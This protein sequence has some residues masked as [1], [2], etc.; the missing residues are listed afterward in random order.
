MTFDLEQIRVVHKNPGALYRELFRGLSLSVSAGECVGIL[1]REGSGKT[2]LL[3]L[4]GGLRRPDTGV[5][6]IDGM[7]PWKPR[8]NGPALRRRIG[9]TFQFPDEQ[10]TCDT[11]AGEITASGGSA[12]APAMK[13]MLRAAGLDPE[14]VLTQSPFTLSIGEARRFAL[15]LTL[16]RRPDAAILDEPTAGLDADGFASALQAIA[17]LRARRATVIFATHDIDFLGAC[18]ERVVLLDEGGI[19]ADGSAIQVLFD[20]PLLASMG[21]STHGA[22]PPGR[23]AEW[24]VGEKSVPMFRGIPAPRPAK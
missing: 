13:S 19:V 14:V 12:V 21:Y 2:T 15:A 7:D 24:P 23:Q 17:E 1:G 18:A 11:V 4:L 5:V 22:A 6:H 20:E 10:F 3:N 9:Y 8:R 16:V